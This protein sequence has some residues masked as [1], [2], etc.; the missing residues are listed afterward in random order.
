MVALD[1]PQSVRRIILEQTVQQRRTVIRRFHRHVAEIE[2]AR[3]Q[4]RRIAHRFDMVLTI[5]SAAWPSHNSGLRGVNSD[6]WSNC[7]EP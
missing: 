4:G 2:Q 5:R 3:Q 6:C 1:N 7:L